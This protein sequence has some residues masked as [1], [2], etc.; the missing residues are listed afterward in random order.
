[1][2]VINLRHDPFKVTPDSKCTP[3]GKLWTM[4]PGCRPRGWHKIGKLIVS[5]TATF[6]IAFGL[7]FAGTLLGVVLRRRL[8][9]P[10]LNAD[11]KDVV[12]LGTGLLGTMAALV[13]GLLIAS[14]KN[15]Y[16]AQSTQI[17][18]MAADLVLLD[19]LLAEYGPAAGSVR[20]LLRRDVATMVDRIWVDKGAEAARAARFEASSADIQ[21]YDAIELLAPK[22]DEQ[23]SLKPRMIQIGTD[24]AQARL[25]LFAQFDNAIPAPFLVVLIFWLTILFM[26][27]SLFSK[28]NAI[29]IAALV[30]FALSTSS[31]LFLIVDLSQPFSGLMQISSA[32]LRH[33]LPPLGS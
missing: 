20:E 9:E 5:S 26:S 12:R 4:M 32:K 18:R 28:P 31:A 21:F 2:L 27:F 8:P 29:V 11:V 33:I 10:H 1:M 13:V 25:L 17:N 22:D 3:D 30:I 14:A 24:L 16:D 7:V 15:S 6:W 23:R 19:H